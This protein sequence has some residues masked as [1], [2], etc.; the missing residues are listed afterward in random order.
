MLSR[1]IDQCAAV[2]ANRHVRPAPSHPA[3]KRLLDQTRLLRPIREK[4]NVWEV[5]AV[6]L[7][8]TLVVGVRYFNRQNGSDRNK[9]EFGTPKTAAANVRRM[10][11]WG[12]GFPSGERKWTLYLVQ[13]AEQTDEAL[14]RLPQ[15]ALPEGSRRV[16]RLREASGGAL[17]AF[18]GE[19]SVEAWIRSFS[20]WFA[21]HNWKETAAWEQSP[22]GWSATFVPSEGG[23]S[24]GRVDVSF[25]R[26]GETGLNGIVSVTPPVR[27]T[28]TGTDR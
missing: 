7:Q 9:A 8:L 5:Y 6:D 22:S 13:S 17:T 12:F 16:L 14:P 2:V 19:G 28:H 25:C 18:E 3:E 10:V 23:T 11:C 27:K 15:I 4:S 20:G 21:R 26:V 24:A 1:L